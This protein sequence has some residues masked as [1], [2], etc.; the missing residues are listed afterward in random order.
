MDKKILDDVYQFW[1]GDRTGPDHFPQDKAKIWFKQSDETDKYIRDTFGAAVAEASKIDWDLDDLTQ[2]EKVALVVLLDQFPRNIFRDSGEAF[3][4][5]A[6]ARSI[7]RPLI[8]SEWEGFSP[9]EKCFVL[10]PME[11][12]EDVADQDL[13]V[14]LY[15]ECAIAA[16]DKLKEICRD[17]LD[18]AT[19]HRDI[20]RKF[21]RFPHRNA[22][23]GR[24]STPEEVEFLKGGRGY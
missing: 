18:Y 8:E 16:S 19:K 14:G 9:A 1:F 22:V 12:S 7:A 24:E 20:V 6:K 21:G 5:D 2:K 15:A 4:Y 3:A 11:H 17:H 23:L 13:S 10:L